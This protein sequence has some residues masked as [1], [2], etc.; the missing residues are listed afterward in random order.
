MSIVDVM[1]KSAYY[2]HAGAEGREKFQKRE[3]KKLV[4]YVRE[5]SPKFAEMY[6]DIGDDFELSDLPVTNKQMIMENFDDW[7]TDRRIKKSEVK[8]FLS[9]PDHIGR[10][11]LDKYLAVTTSGS[12]GHPL[13]FMLNKKSI[14]VSTC[15]ALL[16]RALTHRPVALMYPMKQFLIPTSMI[17]ENMR[18]FPRIMKRSYILM[19]AMMPMDEIVNTLNTMRPETLYSYPSMMELLADEAVDGKL[20]ID[21]KEVV[22]ASEKLTDKTRKYIEDVFKCSAKSIYGCTEGGNLGFECSDRHLHLNNPYSIIEPVDENNNP[23]APG[24]HAHKI[25]LTNLANEVVPIIRYEVMDHIILHTEGCNCKNNS[26]WIEFE[27]RST[28]NLLQ[29]SNG[30]KIVPVVLYFLIETMDTLRR[31][32][33]VLHEDDRLEFRAV[34]MPG[35]DK[36]AVFMEVQNRILSYLKENGVENASVYLSDTA[37]CAD[38][39]TFKFKSVYQEK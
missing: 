4:S 38:P 29:F 10:P 34:F 22:C 15:S 17:M 11:F 6:K 33:I 37:P 36:D 19:D 5:N 7:V 30:V 14:N 16:S 27:G 32:Q 1:L 24:E 9:D 12:S 2:K 26:P 28:G 23:V 39:V 25:L 35:V 13:Y 3:L 31:F 8:E 21:I 20:N 18:R